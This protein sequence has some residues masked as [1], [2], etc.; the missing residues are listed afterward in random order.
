MGIFNESIDKLI[1]ALEEGARAS[2]DIVDVFVE[3]AEGTLSRAKNKRNHLIFGRRGSGKSSLLIKSAEDLAKEGVPVVYIDLEPFKG[4]KYPDIII[5]V[6]ISI[7]IKLRIYFEEFEVYPRIFRRRF[8]EFW[9]PRLSENELKRKKIIADLSG[10]ENELREKLERGDITKFVSTKASEKLNSRQVGA[11][12]GISDLFGGSNKVE[13]NIAAS[14]AK[15]SETKSSEEYERTKSELLV[16]GILRFRELIQQVAENSKKSVYVFLDDLY[17][18][19]KED[20]AQLIDYLHRI[21]KGNQGFLKIGTIRT[22]SKWYLNA[23]QP[24][25]LKIGDDAD[26]INLDKTL[27]K[28]VSTKQ[29]LKS[30]LSE[31]NQKINGSESSVDYISDTG[32][33]RLVLYPTKK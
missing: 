18:V 12:L 23:P 26:E 3:P 4:H 28:F 25:G 5:S 33:D 24:I 9:K 32:L 15:K 10:L 29:F 30:I 2:K 7:I 31:Y 21:L 22:R 1:T 6:L 11:T 19:K 20:Q 13:S 27:E 17:H 14:D 8:W 16:T